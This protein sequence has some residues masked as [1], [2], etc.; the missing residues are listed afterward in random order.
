[1]RKVTL[2]MK[3]QEK[4]NTIKRLAEGHISKSYAAVKIGCTKRHI[5]RLLNRYRSE[6]KQ[7]FLH[8]NT[9]RKPAHAL[10]DHQKQEI[11]TLYCN[12]YWDANFTHACELLRK[13]MIS[14]SPLPASVL[15]SLR[16]PSSLQELPDVPGSSYSRNLKIDWIT[17]L[18]KKKNAASRNRSSSSPMLIPAGPAVPILGR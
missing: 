2:S 1:M 9:G 15:S 18:P 8:G 4:Y 16:K 7:A 3:A 14:P 13:T 12:K 5:N 11:I 10:S 17:L 6:G